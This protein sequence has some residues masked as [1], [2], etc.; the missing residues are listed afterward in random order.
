MP[1]LLTVITPEQLICEHLTDIG[2]FPTAHGQ[3]GILPGHTSL[4]TDVDIGIVKIC[5]QGNW[6]LLMPNGGFAAI[7]NDTTIMLVN[8]TVKADQ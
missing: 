4:L 6:S 1:L 3:L 2:I 8:G 5:I 7:E